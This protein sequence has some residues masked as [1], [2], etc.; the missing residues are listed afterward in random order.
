MSS[1]KWIG[2]CVN[3]NQNYITHIKAVSFDME[4]ETGVPRKKT[5]ASKLVRGTCQQEVKK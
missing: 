4:E 3:G 1:S 2:G 5:F